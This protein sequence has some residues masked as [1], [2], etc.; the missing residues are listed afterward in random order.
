MRTGEFAASLEELRAALPELPEVA[1]KDPRYLPQLAYGLIQLTDPTSECFLST[2]EIE[3]KLRPLIDPVD[4]LQRY[5]W[6]ATVNISG[7]GV[8]DVSAPRWDGEALLVD[9]VKSGWPDLYTGAR[10]RF[11][12]GAGTWTVAEGR[13]PG[14]M[15]TPERARAAVFA[16]F[17]GEVRGFVRVAVEGGSL[18]V[19]ISPVNDAQRYWWRPSSGKGRRFSTW[20]D[21]RGEIEVVATPAALAE[22]VEGVHRALSR[23]R[24][25]SD[26]F[27]AITD[28]AAYR[29]EYK[30]NGYNTYKLRYHGDKLATT[31]YTV[32]DFESIVAPTI[33]GER[34]VAYLS[35]G[36][37]QPHR[38]EIE[39]S[40]L[41]WD[42][43]M[44]VVALFEERLVSDT[45]RLFGEGPKQLTPVP[46]E[47]VPS[48]PEQPR[49]R[50][51]KR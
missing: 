24:V 26:N 16:G 44:K 4:V 20:A 22:L 18:L 45:G 27:R 42:S 33:V 21:L 35:D 19:A 15:H 39:L 14:R 51:G 23:H 8:D 10:Y 11:S 46:V 37:R 6:D 9:C 12:V 1:R 5:D 36:R 28:P 25:T 41:S 32:E 31:E 2:R 17:G 3:A 30:K 38:I 49:L 29:E 7:P 50:P 34:I 47:L 48:A 13:I 43:D 40:T